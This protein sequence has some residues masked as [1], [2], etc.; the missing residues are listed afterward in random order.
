[1]FT[2]RGGGVVMVQDVMLWGHEEKGKRQL[3]QAVVRGSNDEDSDTANEDKPRSVE[4]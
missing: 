1:M 4:S 2:K 3:P